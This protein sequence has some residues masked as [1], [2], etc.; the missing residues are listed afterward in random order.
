MIPWPGRYYDTSSIRC[1]TERLG[2]IHLV[3]DN[4]IWSFVRRILECPS[5]FDT[6]DNIWAGVVEL[7]CCGRKAAGRYTAHT[8][9][10]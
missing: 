6:R 10:S 1:P 8:T 4:V 7:I 2:K 5:G 3:Y 9:C